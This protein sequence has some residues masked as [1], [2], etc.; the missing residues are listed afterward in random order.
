MLKNIIDLLQ[1]HT[2]EGVSDRIEIA[3]GKNSF[4][5]SWKDV[6]NKIKRHAKLK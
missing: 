5:K 4:P 1:L 6:F 3:K 2:Y